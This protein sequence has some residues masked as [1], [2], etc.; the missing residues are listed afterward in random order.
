MRKP[1]TSILDVGCGIGHF[2]Q[3]LQETKLL[4]SLKISYAGIDISPKMIEFAKKKYPKVDFRTVDL[5]KEKFNEKYDL[6]VCSGVFNIRMDDLGQHKETVRKMLSRMYNLCNIGVSANFLAQNS[7]Y[8]AS[9]GIDIESNRYVYFSEEEVL[10]W[11][12]SISGRFVI[13]RDYH[14][15]DFTVFMLK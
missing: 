3:F 14:P 15:G 8:W 4:D 9:E 12:K 11:I 13:R 5:I 7:I 6:V 2:Y 1:K 10:S